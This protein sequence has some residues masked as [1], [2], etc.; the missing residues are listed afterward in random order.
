MTISFWTRD[1]QLVIIK[2]VID[3]SI[4]PD[5]TAAAHIQQHSEQQKK[6]EA[7][8]RKTVLSQILRHSDALI[9]FLCSANRVALPQMCHQ[10]DHSWQ[11]FVWERLH[12]AHHGDCQLHTM[13]RRSGTQK[14]RINTLCVCVR[15]SVKATRCNN[16]VRQMLPFPAPSA[17]ATR[18]ECCTGK[19]C[20]THLRCG[21]QSATL[22][23]SLFNQ[24]CV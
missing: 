12:F 4:L 23:L 20:N 18:Q 16:D 14:K 1:D 7:R 21:W 22:H 17:Q 19:S 10:A 3:R 6:G 11:T 8:L 13:F 5:C 24:P 15:P 9:K 2:R